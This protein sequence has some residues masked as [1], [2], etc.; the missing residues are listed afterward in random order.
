MDR[1]Q[2]SFSWADLA[3]IRSATGGSGGE[4]PLQGAGKE[5]KGCSASNKNSRNQRSLEKL[6]WHYKQ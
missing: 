2:A 4:S 6:V 3:M 1:G 5:T